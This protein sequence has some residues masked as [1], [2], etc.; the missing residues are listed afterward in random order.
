MRPDEVTSLSGTLKTRTEEQI[1]GIARN[2][3]KSIPLLLLT[4][5]NDIISEENMVDQEALSTF[6]EEAKILFDASEIDLDIAVLSGSTA[7]SGNDRCVSKLFRR[8]WGNDG[9][10]KRYSVGGY[11]GYGSDLGTIEKCECK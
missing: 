8:C 4:V 3:T 11:N 1:K 6:L 7:V 9:V 5:W 10:S 2:A